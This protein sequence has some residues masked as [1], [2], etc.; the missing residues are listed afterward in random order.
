[1]VGPDLSKAHPSYL[2]RQNVTMRMG[3]R[4]ARTT[5]EEQT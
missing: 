3:M 2:E 1:M 5:C 4:R